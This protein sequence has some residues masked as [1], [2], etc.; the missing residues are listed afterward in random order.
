MIQNQRS[1]AYHVRIGTNDIYTGNGEK[2]A[3]FVNNAMAEYVAAVLTTLYIHGNP[4]IGEI[5]ELLSDDND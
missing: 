5:D 2:V 1:G 3:T 4:S